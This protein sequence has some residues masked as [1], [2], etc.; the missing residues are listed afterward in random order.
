MR[1]GRGAG[2]GGLNLQ[3]IPFKQ[4]ADWREVEM[5]PD[6][7]VWQVVDIFTTHNGNW[8]VESRSAIRE[9]QTSKAERR[10]ENEAVLA[11]PIFGIDQWARDS[12]LFPTSDPKYNSNGGADHNIQVC[13]QDENGERVAGAGVVF[14]SNGIAGL[15]PPGVDAVLRDTEQHGWCNI[16]IFSP[17]SL[18]PALGPWSTSKLSGLGAADIVTGMGLPWNWH[19]STFIVYQATKWSDLQPTY[20]TLLE[21]LQK[22]AQKE[23]RIQFN[24]NAA[25]QKAIFAAGYVPNSPEYKLEFG[26]T[27][28]IAQRAERLD[29]DEVRVYNC[30]V[31]LYD[32]VTFV[33]GIREG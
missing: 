26:G 14:T 22:T 7:L 4:R 27:Q 33:P 2:P 16:P 28:Y 9:V 32:Q 1:I 11:G 10:E 8:D 13:V 21:A 31:G 19:V 12:Y 3:V 5:Q 6:S 25:L 29:T 23:Q 30:P 18:P 15:Q 20:A 17:P 24:K